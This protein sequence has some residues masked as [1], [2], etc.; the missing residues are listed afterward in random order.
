MKK[1]KFL[2]VVLALFAAACNTSGPATET[3]TFASPTA[4]PTETPASEVTPIRPMPTSMPTPVL[5]QGTLTIKVNVRSGPSTSY[6]SLGLLNAGEKVQI[7]AKDNQGD[8]Y[9]IVY[10]SDP[11]G[12]GWVTAQYVQV[13]AGTEIPLEATAKPNSPTGRITQRLNVRSGPGATFNSLGM[14]QPDTLVSL[15]GKNSMASWFQ[16][17]FAAGPGGH[18]W[19]TAQYVQT[20]SA[21]NLP[22]LDDYGTPVTSS[23]T[24]TPSGPVM[25]P[26]PTVGPAFSDGDSQIAPAINV[27][28]SSAGTRQF[29]YS[30]Q[31]SA[32]DGDAEDW[33]EITPYAASG[34]D[35]R[36]T[37]SLTCTG[38]GT[39]TIEL[40]QGGS[41]LPSWGTLECGDLD[42]PITLPAGQPYEIR[43]TPAPGEGLR[44]VN[45]VLT[46]QN[47]P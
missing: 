22:V 35:A 14:L 8:W 44:L 12:Y 30:S 11:Q 26:T 19:V 20:D 6:E 37:F 28:F 29:T 45:Y 40:W 15:T 42:K 24:E 47:L 25:T 38:N 31:V 9:L 41:A 39:L 23:L 36:L 33:V 1:F 27:T 46:V 4:F 3:I 2:L 5:I 16:I 34:M 13:A 32:P 10:T 7:V 18:G 43:L 21:D 17:D